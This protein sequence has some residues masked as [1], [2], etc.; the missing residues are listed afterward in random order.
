MLAAHKK[1]YFLEC[2]NC[3][4]KKENG[5]KGGKKKGGRK[6]RKG[7]EEERKQNPSQN[8]LKNLKGP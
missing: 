1:K 7:G 2:R 5:R 6:T 3:W 4:E 8:H